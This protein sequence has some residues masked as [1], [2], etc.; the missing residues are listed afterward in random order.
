MIKKV[1]IF[2][3]VLVIFSL[4]ACVQAPKGES[5]V[6][7]KI[8]EGALIIDVRTPGETAAGMYTGAKNIPLSEV[9][10]RLTEFGAKNANIVVYCRS[11]NRSARAKSILEA[12]GYTNVTN[13]GG[14]G[15]MPS[16]K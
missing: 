11:G 12:N 15:D 14:I 7:K 6:L 4:T 5:P 3:I 1:N 16:A 9:E 2:S 8:Q 10:S 13:G